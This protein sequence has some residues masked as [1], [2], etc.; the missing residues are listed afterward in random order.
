MISTLSAIVLRPTPFQE[1]GLV[2]SF[3]TEHGERQVGVV[4]G[5]RKPS[6]KWVSAFE[7]LGLVRVSFFGKEHAELKRVT[8]CELV[9]SPMTL[10]HLESSLVAACLADVF[11]RVAREGVEDDRLY[12]L[13]SA[14]GR[15]LKADPGRALAVLAYA[16][17]WLLHCMGLLPHPRLC[18]RCGG[19]EAP[20]VLFSDEHGWCCAACTPTD[21]REALPPGTREHLRALRTLPA[22]ESPDPGGSDAA[23]AVTHLLRDR[24]RRELGNLR[25]YEV[26]EKLVV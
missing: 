22:A 7:P 17:H 25:S 15:C 16:E 21:P 2:V 8:R 1:G 5:A 10:G 12:R 20:L 24:L 11:D 19:G 18:G 4:K 23:R 13:L 3:L 9:H 6:A 14:C 26:L